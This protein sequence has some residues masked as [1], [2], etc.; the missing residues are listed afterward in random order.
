MTLCNYAKHRIRLIVPRFFRKKTL[1]SVS[2]ATCVWEKDW[3][4]ILLDSEYLRKKQI[5]N[6]CFSFAEKLLIINNVQDLAAVKNA[7]EEK[8]REGIL[9]RYVVAQDLAAEIL[10]FFQLR[11]A[12]LKS[13]PELNIDWTYYNALG[14]L[15]ALYTTQSDYLLYHTGDVYLEKKIDWLGKA[16]RLMVKSENYKVANLLWNGK[17]K[18]AQKE[19]Y[20]RSWNFFFSKKG[21]SDQMFLVKVNDFKQPIYGEICPRSAHFPKGETWERRAFSTL[22]NRGWER[23]TYARG[24]YIHESF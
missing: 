6:H 9:T 7:A 4:I 5:E 24:S 8:I 3:R 11:R 23:L 15:C 22:I 1:P 14:P 21:F 13:S 10:S 19:S 18:E 20:K 12:D 2:F 16:L 17:K